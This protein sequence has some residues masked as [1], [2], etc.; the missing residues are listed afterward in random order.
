MDALKMADYRSA[1]VCDSLPSQ[2]IAKIA[3]N[4][5]DNVNVNVND[6]IDIPKE[7]KIKKKKEPEIIW[8]YEFI[9]K[10]VVDEKGFPEPLAQ[11]IFEYYSTNDW[12]DSRNKKIVNLKQKILANW[13]SEENKLKFK[14]NAS[15]LNK[16]DRDLAEYFDRYSKR[17]A[18]R[19]NP[20]NSEQ[21]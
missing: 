2:S 12:K 21:N 17:Q 18:K 19:N 20:A 8:D 9:K 10:F 14:E 6:N 5:N 16:A 4:V 3:V 13:L 1:I 7:K 15:T 11:R